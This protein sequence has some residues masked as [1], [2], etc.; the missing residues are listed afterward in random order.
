M[1]SEITLLARR[2]LRAIETSPKKSKLTFFITNPP[3]ECPIRII[4][5]YLHQLERRVALETDTQ[6]HL[7]VL[8]QAWSGPHLFEKRLSKVVYAKNTRL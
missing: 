7:S 2:H 8:S 5:V 6:T 4:G 3:I 1:P